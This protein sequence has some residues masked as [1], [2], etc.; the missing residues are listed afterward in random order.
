M[1]LYFVTKTFQLEIA[2]IHKIR[3]AF[4]VWLVREAILNVSVETT[5]SFFRIISCLHH[6]CHV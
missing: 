3:I 5:A 4:V 1:T 2:G 6:N